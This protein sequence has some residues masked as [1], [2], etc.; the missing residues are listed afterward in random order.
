MNPDNISM[1]MFNKAS[2]LRHPATCVRPFA[3][4]M[5]FDASTVDLHDGYASQLPVRGMQND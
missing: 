3:L 5:T 1:F 2:A 4:R